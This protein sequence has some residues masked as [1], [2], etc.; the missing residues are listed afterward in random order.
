MY[1][2][3]AWN[4]N[5]PKA[6]VKNYYMEAKVPDYNALR[7]KAD[8]DLVG[9]SAVVERGETIGTISLDRESNEVPLNERGLQNTDWVARV[10]FDVPPLDFRGVFYKDS[11]GKALMAIFVPGATDGVKRFDCYMDFQLVTTD[12]SL[13]F[14]GIDK[15]TFE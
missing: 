3:R 8:D 10:N 11:K 6:L 13:K 2:Y 15:E 14:F 7:E 9:K 12:E 1:K 5:L 4:V